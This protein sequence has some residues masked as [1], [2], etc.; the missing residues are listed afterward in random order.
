MKLYNTNNY[1]NVRYHRISL[2]SPCIPSKKTLYYSKK[3][4]PR[5]TNKSFLSSNQK[6][7]KDSRRL[8]GFF[9]QVLTK[10]KVSISFFEKQ[11]EQVSNSF[12][13]RAAQKVE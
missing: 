3:L 9:L 13:T 1:T 6:K 4:N 11:Q 8:Y 12:K 10:N 7:V 2:L 5:S